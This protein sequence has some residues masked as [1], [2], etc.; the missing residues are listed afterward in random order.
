VIYEIAGVPAIE[1][2]VD[3]IRGHVQPF[4]VAAIESHGLFIGRLIDERA[5]DPGPEDY[6]IRRVVGVDRDSG[7]VAVDDRIPLGAAIRFH[8]SDPEGAHDEFEQLLTGREADAAL[9][10]LGRS[11]GSRLFDVV[12][13][14]ATAVAE[15]IGS[16]PLSGVMGDGV[17]GPIGGRNFVHGAAATLA[18]FQDR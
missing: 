1:C 15:S 17:I 3:Q 5:D 7:A 8:R 11:R 6:L 14:D 18:L 16:V 13:H 2:L 4:D 9:M 10:F 12:D